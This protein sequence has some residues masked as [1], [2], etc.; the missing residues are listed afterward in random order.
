MKNPCKNCLI[1][2][3]CSKLCDS[4]N[5]YS[6]HILKQFTKIVDEELILKKHSSNYHYHREK[7]KNNVKELR[8]IVIA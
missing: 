6:E 7:C 1:S 8:K 3:N 5:E 2:G 4:K